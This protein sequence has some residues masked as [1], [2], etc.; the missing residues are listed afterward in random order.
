MQHELPGKLEKALVYARLKHPFP[1]E[2]VQQGAKRVEELL[3]PLSALEPGAWEQ[4]CQHFDGRLD[5][6]IFPCFA[7]LHEEKQIKRLQQLVRVRCSWS[8]YEQAWEAFQAYFPNRALELSFAEVYA[9]LRQNPKRYGE[10]PSYLNTNYLPARIDFTLPSEQL[11]DKTVQL[12]KSSLQE[13]GQTVSVQNDTMAFWQYYAIR[14]SQS[15]ACEVLASF[16]LSS[17]EAYLAIFSDQFEHILPKLSRERF[18][19]LMKRVSNSAH[20]A[21]EERR[22]IY[23]AFYHTLERSQHSSE[24]WNS[25]PKRTRE[26]FMR[27]HIWNVMS[28]HY[29]MNP[30]KEKIMKSLIHAVQDVSELDGQTVIWKFKQFYL[31]DSWEQLDDGLYF[32]AHVF[33][34]YWQNRYEVPLLE[35]PYRRLSEEHL[36]QTERSVLKLSFVHPNLELTQRFLS[37]VTGVRF[38]TMP[39]FE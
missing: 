34:S 12:L 8:L 7:Q 37:E 14:P 21:E 4:F 30:T 9:T 19:D 28:Q 15:F 24:L 3:T 20:L 38:K 11:V 25:I 18:V 39:K 31:L 2:K 35:H 29:A 23:R 1:Q 6:L 10:A 33:E 16:L 26:V 5:E 17:P 27:W 36:K 22:P 32:P 13:K